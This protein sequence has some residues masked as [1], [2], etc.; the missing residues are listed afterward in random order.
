MLTFMA[1]QGRYEVVLLVNNG[2]YCGEEGNVTLNCCTAG[3]KEGGGK[4]GHGGDRV[5]VDRIIW[6]SLGLN[7]R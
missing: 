6:E 4:K 1:R 5:A 2:E 3:V 7:I